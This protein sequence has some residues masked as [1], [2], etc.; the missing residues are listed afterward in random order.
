MTWTIR[1]RSEFA[2][3]S[4]ITAGT[5]QPVV[6]I[7]G[8]GLRAEAWN[9]QIDALAEHSHVTAVDLP[10][11]GDSPLPDQA[12][13]LAGYTDAIAEGIETPA[14]LVGHSMGAMIAFDMA[15]RFPGL[16]RGVAALNAVFERAP[17]A[18]EAVRARADSLNGVTVSDPATTLTRWFAETASAERDACR[19]WLLSVDPA[20][21][22]M[23]YRVFAHENGPSREALAAMTCS[24]LFVTGA[25]EANSTPA[26]SQK[27]ACL[28]PNGRA[29]IVPT[30]AHMMPMTHAAIVNAALLKL[31]H[32]VWS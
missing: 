3:L 26:M 18:T 1:Q 5:G 17:E 14:L 29:Q 6:L 32:E 13:C 23:A 19:D 4:A 31:R 25:D 27:M 28:T 7:H 30:A 12:L 10:G 8:V 24:T 22:Q 21:Y 15:A 16:V 20:G 9:P 2:G 11:H